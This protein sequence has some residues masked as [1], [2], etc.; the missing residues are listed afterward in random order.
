VAHFINFCPRY[1]SDL[2]TADALRLIS[3][4]S[5]GV[6]RHIDELVA[7]NAGHGRQRHLLERDVRR[8][9]PLASLLPG[10]RIH[11]NLSVR[12]HLRAGDRR[13]L[14][15]H[16]DAGARSAYEDRHQPVPAEPRR[17]RP[18]TGR[19]LYAIHA[20]PNTAAELRLRQGHVRPHPL[21]AR[22]DQRYT[23]CRPTYIL[24]NISAAATA[25]AIRTRTFRHSQE[26]ENPPHRH[27][28]LVPCDLLTPK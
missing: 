3:D 2:T 19:P 10:R 26:C 18:A 25:T 9:R 6:R 21:H 8:W 15:R 27:C 28:F 23:Y 7:A 16:R 12:D 14:A 4:G 1:A 13:Q 24:C 11:A 17:Q 22:C 20:H 5:N